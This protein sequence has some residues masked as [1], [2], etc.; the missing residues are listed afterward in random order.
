MDFINK[1]KQVILNNSIKTNLLKLYITIIVVMSSILV[2]LLLYSIDLNGNYNK[3]ISNFKNYTN[4]YNTIN[5][6][7]KDIYSNITEQ[8]P[9]DSKNYDEIIN[10]VN[11]SL[12]RININ[13]NENDIYI[14]VEVLKRTVNTLSQYINETGMLIKNNSEYGERENKLNLIIQSKAVIQ[15]NIQQLIAL[16]LTVSRKYIDKKKNLYNFTLFIII[17]LFIVSIFISIGS[18]LLVIKGIVKKIN[19][20]S[21]SANR[22]AN[23][24][25]SIETIDFNGTDEFHILAQSFNKM[26]DNIND[27]ISKI[28]SSEIKISTILNEMNDCVITTNSKGKIDSCNYAVEKMFKYGRDEILEF[29]INKLIPSIDFSVFNKTQFNIENLVKDTK[30]ID[31]K[32]QLMGLKKDEIL[33]PIELNCKEIELDGSKAITF[34]IHDITQHKEIERMKN[35]FISTV[36]HELRTPLT[37]IR[38]SLGLV[39]SEALGKLPEKSK[40]LLNIANNNSLRLINLINDI[41]DLEKIKAG[42]MEFSFKEYEVMPLVE[43]SIK[44]NEEYAK[45]Y[46]VRYE[47]VERLDQSF[48]NVDK[49]KFIQVLTNLLSNAAKFSFA[50]EVVE[51]FVKR[52]RNV[53][54]ISVVNKGAGIPEESYSKI[55]ESFSQVDSSDSRKKGGT[56][57]GL[58]ITKSIIQK[59]GGQ[60]GF[61]S[62]LNEYTDFYFELPEIIKND[63]NKK[64]L[65][66]EDN[67]T[68]AFCIKSMFEKIGYNAD[69]ALSAK[70][71]NQFLENSNYDLMTLDL[72][73]PDKDGSILLNEM[74]NNPKTKD[75]P[76]IIISVSKPDDEILRSHHQIIDWLEKS[77]NL[78]DLETSVNNIMQSK[79]AKKVEILH[80]ENDE[81]ILSIIDLT[82]KD[83]ANVTGIRTLSEAKD[84]ISNLEFDI[85]ILDYIFPEGTSDKLIPLIKSGINKDAK[86]VIFSSYEESKIL[87]RYFD[88]IFLK[89]N[90]SN[91]QFRNSIENFINAKANI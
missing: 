72:V 63:K 32:Y 74:G 48:I 10:N 87:S 52:K 55:F 41:L 47:L 58:S 4:I 28:S 37:S 1:L 19:I 64:V 66:C 14:S 82:L 54:L 88:A 61:T 89:T 44:L 57:L 8:K 24:D 45:L 15:D 16:D 70:E 90:V 76:I 3:I 7:D 18:L 62:K 85:I 80:V 2:T 86:L 81:D 53:V 40:E 25:L 60:I 69:I 78:T 22:L 43:E 12:N 77:F 83:V 67:K 71:A 59:M 11:N 79:N 65:V 56:G 27:Y 84:I 46:N 36:S 73:L 30:M 68:T 31:N 26:K 39:L 5:S 33:F 35:E 75:L 20:V 21:E 42:K 17:I 38:G 34:V 50:D 23:G 13:P 91:E 51:I 6:I 9:F 49:G 29:N